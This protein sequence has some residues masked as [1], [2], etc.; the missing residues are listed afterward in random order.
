M[1]V[2][3]AAF[4]EEHEKKVRPVEVQASKAWWEANVSGSDEAF[5]RKAELQ[6]QLD[7]FL[8]NNESFAK[9]KSIYEDL[10]ND[11]VKEDPI[12]KRQI[13]VLY[14]AYL[15]KHVD[16]SLLSRM[17]EL[18]NQVEK[19]F[20]TFRAKVDDKELTQNEVSKILKESKDNTLRKKAWEGSKAVGALVEPTLLELVK[21]R[22]E[23]AKKLGF[24]NYH[25]M[26]LFLNEQDYTELDE[27][28]TELDGL[29]TKPFQ[30]LKKGMDEEI[31][32]NLGLKSTEELRPWHYKDLFFQEATKIGNFDLDTLFADKDVIKLC[33]EFYRSIGLPIDNILEKSSL[34]EQPGK[35]PHA[36]CIDIDREG[37]VRVLANILPDA[38]WMDTMLHELGHG[39]YSSKYIPSTL[40]YLLRQQSHILTTEG[41]AML[42]GRLAKNLGFL[43]SMKLTPASE[44]EELR[45]TC[46]NTLKSQ[47][48]IFSRWVQVMFYFER[49]LYCDPLQDLNK[50]WWDLVEKYQNIHR[51]DGRDAPDYASKI[52]IVVAPV[53]YHNYLMGE[54]FASQVLASIRKHLYPGQDRKEV[55]LV[56][57]PK[58]GEFLIEKVFAVGN[59]LSWKE[60]TK[61]ATGELLNSKEFAADFE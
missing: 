6:N 30:Q 61:Y 50:K 33:A 9:I 34:Y 40:P 45:K 28:F 4:I 57:N 10:R 15:E 60:L 37:D 36:F 53:Y 38:Y 21:I 43:K 20:N 2:S 26:M 48:L 24:G 17:V 19:T 8:S 3:A 54:M 25:E 35:S 56:G 18:S 23:V 44:L 51:P 14:K 27:L 55:G 42:F 46:E 7:S 32:Q 58:V 22:N 39:C 13:D 5:A 16:P 11:K 41:I 52:H 29:T 47:L 12:T 59:S 1:S 31:V 49:S